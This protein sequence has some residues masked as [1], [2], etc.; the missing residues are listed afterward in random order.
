MDFVVGLV[1]KGTYQN[2]KICL[3]AI[4]VAF[5]SIENVKKDNSINFVL[6]SISFKDCGNRCH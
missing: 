2:L 6:V 1:L 5:T 4:I 3:T